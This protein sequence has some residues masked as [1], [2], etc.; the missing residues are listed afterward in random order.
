MGQNEVFSVVIA[1]YCQKAFWKDAVDSV[2]QQDYPQI[3]L[4]FA[5]DGSPNFCREEVEDYIRQKK[6][7]NLV[8]FEVLTRERNCGTVRSMNFAHSRCTGTY[9]MNFAAD[10]ALFDQSVL[11]RFV[12]ALKKKQPDV[13][14]VYGSAVLCTKTLETT[15]QFFC[16]P[17]ECTV[18]NTLTACKQFEKL[19]LRCFILIGGAAFYS[20]DF[21]ACGPYDE[22]YRLIEDWPFLLKITKSG[23]RMEYAGF[24]ALKYRAGGVSQQ[25]GAERLSPA[26][27][28]CFYDHIRLLEREILPMT[29]KMPYGVADRIWRRYDG[30]RYYLK[31]VLGRYPTMGQKKIFKLDLRVVPE[32][33]LYYFYYHRS[34]SIWWMLLLCA[35]VGLAWAFMGGM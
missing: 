3:E 13:A 34:C 19:A 21:N 23:R 7:E 25:S 26:A 9:R 12:Q 32:R 30:D 14:G 1:H 2:L 10:D 29:A 18:A 27:T 24:P 31:R 4:I 8:R 28:Q 16:E 33:I 6:K 17:E 5:D 11:T 22:D 20:R 15:G 35:A